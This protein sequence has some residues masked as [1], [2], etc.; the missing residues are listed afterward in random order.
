MRLSDS[1]VTFVAAINLPSAG[2][3]GQPDSPTTGHQ[4]MLVT[5]LPPRAS[6]FPSSSIGLAL[7]S[8]FVENAV[9]EKKGI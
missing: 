2:Q 1:S 3:V 6:T 5:Y 7:M 4:Q 9:R 8:L